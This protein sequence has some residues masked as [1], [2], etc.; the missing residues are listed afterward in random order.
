MSLKTT[1]I[2][3]ASVVSLI[4]VL[5]TSSISAQW[6]DIH[7]TSG[8]IFDQ[9]KISSQTVNYGN[10]LSMNTFAGTTNYVVWALTIPRKTIVDSVSL[11]CNTGSTDTI[12]YIQVY[13]G[14]SLIQTIS[15]MI[16]STTIQKYD[17]A[18]TP[19]IC[20]AGISIRAYVQSPATTGTHYFR[21]V[22]ASY[23]RTILIIP[24][25]DTIKPN[26]ET[27]N[28]QLNEEQPE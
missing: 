11:T 3:Y 1:F 2:Y 16:N 6:F 27:I 10:Y 25:P 9:S 7:G 14:N 23:H 26:T 28:M 20:T 24:P 17:F 21:F 18:I 5:T 4:I 8:F 12:R 13:N 19:F 22:T 15:C